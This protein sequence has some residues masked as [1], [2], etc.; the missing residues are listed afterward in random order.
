[1]RK[2]LTLICLIA[3]VPVAA[4]LP[5]V[6][7]ADETA[8]ADTLDRQLLDQ[9]GEGE[10]IELPHREDPLTRIGDRMRTVQRLISEKNT[11]KSTQGI[12]QEIVDKLSAL[13]EQASRQKKQSSGGAGTFPQVTRRE[14]VKQPG[15]QPD[16]GTRQSDDQPNESAERR[17][18]AEARRP[19]M[20]EMRSLIERE[21]WGHLPARAREQMLRSHIDRFLPKY[22]RLIEEYFRRLAEDQEP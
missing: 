21:I 18:K 7:W 11:S 9:L 20:D 5:C 6:A 1:M 22:E 2:H 13:M 14:S 19:D 8:V 17:G 3:G 15:S 4:P 16:Q 12:Q 10:D